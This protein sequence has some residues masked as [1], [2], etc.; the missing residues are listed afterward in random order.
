MDYAVLAAFIVYFIV[1]LGVGFYFYKR[2]HGME[3]YFLGGRAMNPYV[4]ALS[5]Q[6]SDM[7]SWMLMGLPGVVMLLGLG[8]AWIGIGLAAGSYLSWLFVAKKLRKHSVVAGNALTVPE[9]FSNRYKDEKGYLRIAC[10]V[11][12]LF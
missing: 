2:S 3:D 8:E 4:T 10:A 9:F 6:A 7:S 5:A 12:I 1:V 11:I